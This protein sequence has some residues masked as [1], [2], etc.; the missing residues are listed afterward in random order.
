[1]CGSNISNPHCGSYKAAVRQWGSEANDSFPHEVR[2]KTLT[3]AHQPK[4]GRMTALPFFKTGIQKTEEELEKTK[5]VEVL[6]STHA[7]CE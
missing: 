1:V 3:T 7:N 4:S 2:I 6:Y 5:K